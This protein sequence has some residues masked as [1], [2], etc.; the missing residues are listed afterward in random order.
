ML[1]IYIS[2]M[3]S[4]SLISD[5]NSPMMAL[6]DADMKKGEDHLI[7]YEQKILRPIL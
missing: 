4:L 7:S 1:V 6:I 5:Y 3:V 2:Y